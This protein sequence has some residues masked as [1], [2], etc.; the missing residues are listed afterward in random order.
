MNNLKEK[1]SIMQ[2]LYEQGV[3]INFYY[4]DGG[5]KDKYDY[6]ITPCSEKSFKKRREVCSSYLTPCPV[7]WYPLEQVLELLPSYIDEYD[8]HLEKA[9]SGLS[10]CFNTIED[11]LDWKHLIDQEV[12][13][14][15]YHLA[16]LKLLKQVVE[17]YPES[18]ENGSK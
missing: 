12:R 1:L 14:N 9:I 15:D 6:T 3:E 13:G 18:V 2:W 4:K 7:P 5:T 11:P 16:A 10:Y 8:L 17:K